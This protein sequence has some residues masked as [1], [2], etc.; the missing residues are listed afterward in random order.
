LAIRSFRR[1]AANRQRKQ[2]AA[3]GVF[4]YASLISV[5]S[6]FLPSVASAQSGQLPGSFP[7]PAGSPPTGLQAPLPAAAGTPVAPLKPAKS[8]PALQ[9][10]LNRAPATA[11][12]IQDCV[13]VALGSSKT[14]ALAEQSL[15]I[16]QGKTSEA[17]AA[18]NP[19]FGSTFT[20]TQF[21]RETT[22][23]IGTNTIVLS[24]SFQKQIGVAATLPIDISGL[25]RAAEDQAKL[26]EVI[27]RLDINRTRNQIVLDVKS[28]FYDVLR[29]K[30]L[31]DV[32]QEAL[33]N[34][35]TRQTDSQKRL[36][37]GVVAP[38]DAQRAA[39]DVA[40]AQLNLI[41]AQNQLSQSMYS[42][43]N[44]M[45]ID[46]NSQITV[47][48]T[49]A[50]ETPPGVIDPANGPVIPPRSN[51]PEEPI[52]D[53]T[54]P[55]IKRDIVVTDPLPVLPDYAGLLAEALRTRPEIMEAD[56]G[57]AAAHKGIVLAKRS[58]DPSLGVVVSGAYSPDASGLGAQTTAAQAVVTLNVPIY[59]GGVSKARKL[60]AEAAQAQ[61]LTNRRIAEDGIVFEVQSAY[62]SLRIGR[63]SLAVANQSVALARE[64]FRLARVRY[65][66]GVTSQSGVSPL[67]ELSDAQTALTQAESNQVNA[68]Y[69]YNNARSRLDKALGRYAFVF[70]GGKQ[71]SYLGYG[72]P[73]ASKEVTGG[74][75]AKGDKR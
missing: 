72:A 57:I 67:I 40:S 48:D 39:T 49:G 2:A 53:A 19:T 44:A 37:A 46:L 69:N 34:S 23:T 20:A 59:E 56:A 11:L 61:A 33:K 1:A 30:S 47:T 66:A 32:S 25:L 70:N 8:S 75:H 15:L 9:G 28:A 21:S 26:Q 51:A 60:Q 4:A 68:L 3:F 10:V 64:A 73:P 63:D 16:S 13:A 17:K 43:K 12:N 31:L 71:P 36:D 55:L 65:S 74:A 24:K 58:Q 50:A 62:Q 45:G 52:P 54:K 41:N 5:A 22:A 38:Y 29:A 6:A 35:I 7:F 18:F 14:L 27:A 42:L